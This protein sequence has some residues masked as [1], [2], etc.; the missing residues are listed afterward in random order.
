MYIGGDG[1][2]RG[3]RSR[4]ELSAEKFIP[5]SFSREPGARLYKT[6]DR[7]RYRP[8]GNIEFLGRLDD[9]VKL[10]GLRIE[11]GEIEAVLG[12]HPGVR[13]TVVLA[14]EDVP[15]E[16]RLVGYL[17]A[18]Q[19]SAPSLSELYTFLRDRLPD[20]MIPTLVML[21]TLPL[22]P[23]GKVDRRALPAP[24]DE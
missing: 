20:Y 21:E 5:N 1:L 24:Q 11:L 15:G 19:K 8:D 23:N 2:A 7:A 16:R 17:V 22:T 4:P 14:R 9:Q 3:Y 10:R 13:D 6:G 18:A 12:S